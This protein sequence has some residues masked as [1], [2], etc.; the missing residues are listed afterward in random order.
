[1]TMR[2]QWKTDVEAETDV[3]AE[4]GDCR[5]VRLADGR[6]EIRGGDGSNRDE[7]REWASMFCHEALPGRGR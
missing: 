1:M 6:T 2:I 7:A 5:I 4:F 3:V